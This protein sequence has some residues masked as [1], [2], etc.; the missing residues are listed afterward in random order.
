M[1]TG[2]VQ[3]GVRSCPTVGCLNALHLTRAVLRQARN[4]HRVQNV[5]NEVVAS[6]LVTTY[7]RL[8]TD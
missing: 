6:V 4:K 5:Y 1:Q 8:H 7:E 2:A 3:T